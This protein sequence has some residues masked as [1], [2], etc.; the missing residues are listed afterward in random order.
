MNNVSIGLG[1][2]HV[3]FRYFQALIIAHVSPAIPE[4]YGPPKVQ[5]TDRAW[6]P[7]APVAMETTGDSRPADVI[8]YVIINN[9]ATD[10]FV[11]Y[12]FGQWTVYIE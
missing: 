1:N 12:I 7:V 3:D 6:E 9:I 2:D 10:S 4:T 11:C 5:L 8:V